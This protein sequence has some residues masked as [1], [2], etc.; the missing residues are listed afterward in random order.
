MK[1]VTNLIEEA[2]VEVSGED[3]TKGFLGKLRRRF[4]E[5]EGVD[6]VIEHGG[7]RV[8][9]DEA[10]E[11]AF[12]VG[13]WV[14]LEDAVNEVRTIRSSEFSDGEVVDRPVA[15]KGGEVD[16]F[17]EDFGEFVWV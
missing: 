4:D 14:G 15:L 7:A 11:E 13:C 12:G 2:I 5:F 1:K 9:H 6:C 3:G 8:E 10:D 16:G 17:L